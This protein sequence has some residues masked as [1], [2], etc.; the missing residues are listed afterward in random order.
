MEGG[1]DYVIQGVTDIFEIKEVGV[2][3][4]VDEVQGKL[5]F[6]GRGVGQELRTAFDAFV[7]I[8]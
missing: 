1:Q 5:V 8:S 7:A 4:G 3:A 2:K 6:I